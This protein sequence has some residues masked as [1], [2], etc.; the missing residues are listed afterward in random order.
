MGSAG[1]SSLQSKPVPSQTGAWAIQGSGAKPTLRH[2][3][4]L[5][6][7][8]RIGAKAD[9]TTSQKEKV[10]VSSET[11]SKSQDLVL[12]RH[13]DTAHLRGDLGRRTARGAALTM[14]SHA[15]RFLLETARIIVLARLLQPED[16][17]LVAMVT[18]ITGFIATFQDLGLNIATVTRERIT[19][20]QVS[21]LFWVN[22]GVA[23]VLVVATI[24]VA[25]ALSSVYGESRLV[26]I[27]LA[28]APNF[29]LA[30]LAV[31]HQA[32]L[33]RQ[34]RFGVLSGIHVLSALVGVLLGILLAY[35]GA[36]YWALVGMTIG[37]AATTALSVWIASRWRPG[38]PVR[39]VGTKQMIG[40]GTRITA[41]NLV[42]YFSRSVD[43]LLL[44]WWWGPIPLGFYTKASSLVQAPMNRAL[45]PVS[46][47]VV[48]SLSRLV[49]EP[50][51]YREAYLRILEKLALASMPMAVFMIG[52]AE[53]LIPFLLG[54]RWAE[55]AP[56]FG[57]LAV[58]GFVRPIDSSSW[59]LFV[60]QNRAHEAF[61]WSIVAALITA[62]AVVAGVPWG[63][64]GIATGLAVSAVLRLPALVW[65]ATRRGPVRA[66]DVYRTAAAPALASACALLALMGLGFRVQGLATVLVLTAAVAIVVIVV[67]AILCILPTGRRALRDAWSLLELLSHRRAG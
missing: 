34:M 6:T 63:G 16:Y 25:P 29:L 3:L 17:G 66:Y 15:L 59:W 46:S 56:I 40:F 7:P 4:A 24:A 23:M 42:G 19:H 13:F 58:L 52:S 48:P 22:I 5:H 1:S 21:N 50:D 27:T 41:S 2:L 55:T 11:G 9:R 31:Q 45:S 32:L 47:V 65:Y 39:G 57:V 51:R 20:A 37:S 61:R 30:G 8:E 14:G 38:G 28:L 35:E 67:L 26:P 12:D 10:G 54:P 43:H 33:R 36:T 18:V 44:G 62:V 64:V 53:W 49:R 60:T